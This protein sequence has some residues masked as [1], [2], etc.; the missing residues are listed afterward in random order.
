MEY[1][2]PELLQNINDCKKGE[3]EIQRILSVNIDDNYMTLKYPEKG[4]DYKNVYSITS[5]G[6][7]TKNDSSEGEKGLGFKKVFSVFEEV[8][9]Y[10]NGFCFKLSHK[11]RTI[12]NTVPVWINDQKKQI[13]R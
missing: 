4:F 11:D 6:K 13:Y 7:S 2:I 10:S 12:D 9:I 3:N 1:V 8:E 5:I